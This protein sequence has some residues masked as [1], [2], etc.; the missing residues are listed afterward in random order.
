MRPGGQL[1]CIDFFHYRFDRCDAR[2]LAQLRGLLEATGA[3]RSHGHLPADPAAAVER[4]E[5]EWK[6][7]HV[8]EHDLNRSADIEVL[9]SHWLPTSARS[10]HPYLCWD[11][12]EALDVPTPPPTRPP[13]RWSPTGRSRSSRPASSH[14]CFCA[15][16]ASAI[17]ISTRAS[18]PSYTQ[19]RSRHPRRPV[20]RGQRGR[21]RLR[22]SR[23]RQPRRSPRHGQDLA[24]L[25]GRGDPPAGVMSA[26]AGPARENGTETSHEELTRSPLR[27]LAAAT[28]R[29]S[30]TRP[31]GH[32]PI[33]QA[34]TARDGQHRRPPRRGRRPSS[35]RPLRRRPHPR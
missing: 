31:D 8:V 29:E 13:P 1:V 21:K 27:Q 10:W 9:L 26:A 35:A 15:L 3:Y 14:P 18:R 34:A 5:W 28:F 16:S 20:R 23:S 11:I 7:E 25:L 6:Q 2:W 22:G 12:L 32:S 4:I 30:V 17:P 24:R 33:R 19:R